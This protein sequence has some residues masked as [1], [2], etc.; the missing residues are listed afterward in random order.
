MNSC[1]SCFFAVW[2]PSSSKES[3][4][5]YP[6]ACFVS[7]N[8]FTLKRISHV[9]PT[10]AIDAIVRLLCFQSKEILSFFITELKL[11][12][13]R[14]EDK[15]M[16]FMNYSI[17]IKLSHNGLNQSHFIFLIHFLK[18]NSWSLFFF[19]FLINKTKSTLHNC[20]GNLCLNLWA[21]V[22]FSN[23]LPSELHVSVQEFVRWRDNTD[24]PKTHEPGIVRWMLL[25]SLKILIGLDDAVFTIRYNHYLLCGRL[26]T[27]HLHQK[28]RATWCISNFFENHQNE[29]RIV[30]LE[31]FW[32]ENRIRDRFFSRLSAGSQ[33]R[34]AGHRGE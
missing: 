31:W 15:A 29:R 28:V 8:Y 13:E 34:P 26:P 11:P 33:W 12:L 2:L 10:V 19:L 23:F 32:K 7:L 24:L 16:E 4:I 3:L 30:V 5:I 6:D 21:L 1:C 18:L 27:F 25:V 22:Y 14:T 17:V 9:G 20:H